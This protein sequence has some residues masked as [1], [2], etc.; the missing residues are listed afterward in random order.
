MAAAF[1]LSSTTNRA[2]SGCVMLIGSAP[3]NAKK[4]FTSGAAS[5]RAIS[6]ESVAMTAGGV[7]VGA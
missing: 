5:A 6:R 2:N 3:C 4:W 7:P 1:L